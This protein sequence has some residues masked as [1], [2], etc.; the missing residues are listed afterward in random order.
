MSTTEDVA[1]PCTQPDHHY[2]PC[3]RC[4]WAARRS[5]PEDVHDP[6]GHLPLDIYYELPSA[7]RLYA[8]PDG[9][10]EYICVGCA[11]VVEQPDYLGDIAHD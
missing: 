11:A 2:G 5:I 6:W 8:P 9:H 3:E 10:A 4:Y 1:D 7:T